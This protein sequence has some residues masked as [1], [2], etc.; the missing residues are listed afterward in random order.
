M[1]P[2]KP[3]IAVLL[4][5]IESDYHVEVLTGVLRAARTRAKVLIV[6]GGWLSR[7]DAEPLARN[8]IY[9]F[10]TQAKIDGVLALA[11]SLSNYAGL[12]RFRE[13]LKR[14]AHVPVVT[15]GIDVP[16]VASVWV[17]NGI[18][19][20]SVVSHLVT[21]H[22]KRRIA[23]VRGPEA[24][25]EAETRRQAYRRALEEQGIQKDDRLVV[26]GGFERENGSAAISTLLDE[27]RFTTAT[28]DAVVGVNDETALGAIE[29][30]TRR[31]ISVPQ[32]IAVVG[33]DDARSA[34]TGNPPLTTVSQRIDFQASAATRTLLDAI[35]SGRGA[36]GTKL[37]PELV[38]R[39]SCGC[40]VRFHNDSTEVRAAAGG[41]ARSAS[42]FLVERR[43]TTVAELARAAAGRLVG[44]PGWE[45]R[46]IDGLAH[47]L[48]G[49]AESSF[50]HEVEQFARKNVAFGRDVT[51]CHDVLTT[52]R[53]QAVAATS[54]EPSARPRVEDLFQEARLRIARI[55]ADVEHDRQQSLNHHARIVTKACLAVVGGGD[56]RTLAQAL[57]EHLPALGIS[58]YTVTR[59]KKPA[60]STE[61]SVVARFAP[62]ALTSSVTALPLRELGID[63]TLERE[64]AL[65]VEPLEFAG[66]AV[67][68][69]AFAW[70]AHN[71]FHYEALREVLGAAVHA[72]GRTAA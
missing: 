38:V 52:L 5:H 41:M 64:D 12:A 70:G 13:W 20:H 16:D 7:S 11:G 62:N 68:I 27:R 3:R 17:D 51:V 22:G 2:G 21:A 49:A 25:P 58:A 42:L 69:G 35:A 44:M 24:S 57:A 47:D 66:V 26:P 59:L 46:L 67:G 36:V 40:V 56:A 65:V 55:G 8:F 32:P 33:F 63:P 23:F 31:G 45:T 37:D 61:L 71:P 43:A 6:P 9:D 53:L 30:L 72:L 28:L 14:F 54:V 19:I 10:L 48:G 39:A 29:E 4:D 18:G 1:N 50:V 34:R 60:N 15:V